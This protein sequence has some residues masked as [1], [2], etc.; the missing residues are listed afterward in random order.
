MSHKTLHRDPKYEILMA[1]RQFDNDDTGKVSF[2]NLIHGH[3]GGAECWYT[4]GP[5]LMSLVPTLE[6]WIWILS[7]GFDCRCE[8]RAKAKCL[9]RPCIAFSGRGGVDSISLSRLLH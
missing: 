3:S 2:V 8:S 6:K 5:W 7:A 4:H 1:F 9:E